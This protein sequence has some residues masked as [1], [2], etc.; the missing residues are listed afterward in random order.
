MES[1]PT[2]LDPQKDIHVWLTARERILEGS[3][4]WNRSCKR[5]MQAEVLQRYC[6]KD[7]QVSELLDFPMLSVLGLRHSSRAVPRLSCSC[8]QMI[9][10]L[11]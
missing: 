10:A 8:G 11:L 9:I 5:K 2:K 4:V 6:G 1:S 3:G 7:V